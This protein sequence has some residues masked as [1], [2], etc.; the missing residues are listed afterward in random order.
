MDALVIG[1]GLDYTNGRVFYR[2]GRLPAHLQRLVDL[3]NAMDPPPEVRAAYRDQAFREMR[4]L[5]WERW[6]G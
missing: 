3:A 1:L 5:L 4:Q 6:N 2:R